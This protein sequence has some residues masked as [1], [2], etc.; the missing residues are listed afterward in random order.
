MKI[1]DI[2]TCNFGNSGELTC[3]G[4]ALAGNSFDVDDIVV[5]ITGAS[6]QDTSSGDIQNCL[7]TSGWDGTLNRPVFTRGEETDF[8]D[9]SYAIVEWSGS[10][11]AVQNVTHAFTSAATQTSNLAA[12]IPDASSAFIHTQQRN[13][14]GSCCD[15]IETSGSEVELINTNEIQ[16]RLPEGT[17]DWDGNQFA[18]TWVISNSETD[19]G[20]RMIVNRYNPAVVDPPGYNADVDG[21]YSWAEPITPLTYYLN[22][23]AITGFSAQGDGGG[24]AYPRS[25]AVGLLNETDTAYL[26][27]SDAA[28]DFSSTFEIV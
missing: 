1:L 22:G 12:S 17:G 20:E 7:V 3:N 8:C 6:N 26:W 2:D 27:Q 18:V 16:Y 25:F 13:A 21:E 11:W 9:V 10:N 23:S 24:N 19:V 5:W 28:N 14:G 15:Q 4:T